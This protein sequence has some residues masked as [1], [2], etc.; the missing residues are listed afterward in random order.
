MY[1]YIVCLFTF[2]SLYL[3]YF[4]HWKDQTWEGVGGGGGGSIGGNASVS[5]L[6]PLIPS[7]QN[8]I[9][10]TPLGTNM[11]SVL[12]VYPLPS[13]NKIV[14]Q[15]NIY[16]SINNNKMITKAINLGYL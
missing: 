4:P 2:S 6:H 15:E 11:S 3:S 14:T 7:S 9:L 12:L 13:K 8:K 10:S 1:I 16:K 5:M